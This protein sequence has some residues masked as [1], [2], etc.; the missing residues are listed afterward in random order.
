MV[1]ISK[2]SVVTPC[3]NHARYLASCIKSVFSQTIL[4]MEMIIVDDGSKDN[5]I[6]VAT[7]FNKQYP[8]KVVS[9][10]ENKGPGFARNVGVR[11][12]LGDFILPLDADDILSSFYIEKTLPVMSSADIVGVGLI[13]IGEDDNP[14]DNGNRVTYPYTNEAMLDFNGFYNGCKIHYCSLYKREIWEKIG[15]YE[16]GYLICY[17]DWDFW[18]RA[19]Y[20]GY[21]VK[22]VNELLLYYRSPSI[23]GGDSVYSRSKPH[24]NELV[25]RMRDR[26]GR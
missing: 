4:P 7:S 2:V 8:I 13:E 26:V 12:A 15:G 5:S 21:K 14:L 9:Y 16:E 10:G 23:K 24:H 20:K 1:N 3:Y 22:T 17:E 25:K 19:T 18:L 11:E 6:E